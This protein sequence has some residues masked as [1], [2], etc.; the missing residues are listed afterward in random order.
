MSFPDG[1]LRLGFKVTAAGSIFEIQRI[2]TD[3]EGQ[4]GGPMAAAEAACEK[5]RS[6]ALAWQ[7]ALLGIVEDNNRL[8][9]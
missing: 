3:A 9:G 1:T 5:P 4:E 2:T 7:G 8:A 6:C